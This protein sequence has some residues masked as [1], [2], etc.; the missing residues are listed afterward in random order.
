[1]ATVVDRRGRA[2]SR[3]LGPWLVIAPLALGLVVFAVLHPQR[4]P[5]P[6]HADPADWRGTTT[7]R[8]AVGATIDGRWLDGLSV[9]L[10]LRCDRGARPETFV[11]TP[12]PDL[13]AQHG[14]Q[15]VAHEALRHLPATDGWHRAFDGQL[16]MVVGDRPHGTTS[17]TLRWTRGTTEVLCRS[18]S[19]AFSLRRG[20]T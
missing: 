18:G 1:M 9:R 4:S 17:A 16:R 14:D 11:W 8:L 6:T 7:Q 20:A 15:L 19:V 10:R 2:R 3:R 13:Y 5:V 12:S